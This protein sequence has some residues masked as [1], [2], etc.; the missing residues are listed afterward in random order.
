LFAL[1]AKTKLDGLI[2]VGGHRKTLKEKLDF[3]PITRR[4]WNKAVEENKYDYFF[5][6]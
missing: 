1:S 6:K 3:S 4:A 5:I 2:N